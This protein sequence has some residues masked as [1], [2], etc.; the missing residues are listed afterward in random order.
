MYG[1][2]MEWGSGVMAWAFCVVCVERIVCA[3]ARHH[4]Y[5]N[6]LFDHV[7][8][9]FVLCIINIQRYAGC[10][11]RGERPESRFLVIGIPG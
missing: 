11:P 2:L 5:N 9:M 6:E 1:F 7:F 4:S 10:V 8:N 3:P